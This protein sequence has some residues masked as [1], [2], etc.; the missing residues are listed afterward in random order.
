M[1]YVTTGGAARMLGVG[2][3]T[4]KRWIGSGDLTGIQTPGGHWRLPEPS[5][6]S[7]MRKRGMSIPTSGGSG[8]A[9]VLVIDD[10]PATWTLI[11]GIL[12]QAEFSSQV[13]CVGDGY[14]GL[15][16]I[17]SWQP[18][19]LVLDI[20]MPGINGL[21]VLDRLRSNQQLAGNMAIIVVTAAFDEPDISR[22][23]WEATPNAL[24]PKPVEAEQFLT[25]VR[26]ALLSMGILAHGEYELSRSHT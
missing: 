13:K 15:V 9:K 16:E 7:F 25:T 2:V 21:E 20:L 26:D 18:D 11:E 14:T 17:G 12:E 24:L 23:V 1:V 19:V 8:P 22:Q 6:L 10:D 5:L 4:V 3:N